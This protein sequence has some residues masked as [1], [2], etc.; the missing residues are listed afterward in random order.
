[1]SIPKKG[2]QITI[3]HTTAYDKAGKPYITGARRFIQST[4]KH[5]Y[6]DGK[7]QTSSG[8]VWS[9]RRGDDGKLV[10]TVQ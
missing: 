4:V 6:H 9:C 2:E 7:V 8:D 5:V 10:T 3:K 1:M